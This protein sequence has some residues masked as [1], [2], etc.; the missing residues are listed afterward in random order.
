[1]SNTLRKPIALEAFL[2][3]EA[4]QELRWEFDGIDAVA[5]TG[6]LGPLGYRT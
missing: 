2:A 4:Q 1:M 3:W 6:H 5:M